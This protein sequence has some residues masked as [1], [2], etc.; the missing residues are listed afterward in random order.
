MAEQQERERQ[1][2]EAVEE[3]SDEEI[4]RL[5]SQRFQERVRRVHAA[6][7]RE[8]VDWRGVPY[9]APDGRIAVR[10]VPVDMGE[11]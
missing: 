10:V 8:R 1:A 11:R 2:A 6:M 7:E 9:I 5:K 3:L 4:E